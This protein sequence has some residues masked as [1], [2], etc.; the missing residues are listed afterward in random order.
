[1]LQNML[2]KLFITL[3][4]YALMEDSGPMRSVFTKIEQNELI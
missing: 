4:L 2:H 3:F 1:M